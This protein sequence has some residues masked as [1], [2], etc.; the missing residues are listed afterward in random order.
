MAI[1]IMLAS[2]STVTC[3]VMAKGMDNDEVLS[4]SIVVLTTLLSSVTLT[5]WIFILRNFGLRIFI[6]FLSDN[7]CYN[8]QA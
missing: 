5:A 3:F 6:V 4:S 7:S 2:P 1:L 8:R